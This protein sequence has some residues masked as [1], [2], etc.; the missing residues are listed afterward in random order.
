[1]RRHPITRTCT[2]G[3]LIRSGGGISGF[4]DSLSWQI[5]ISGSVGTD[6]D[7]D[8]GTMN[9]S[10]TI[11]AITAQA[12]CHASTLRTD[13]TE[14]LL[15]TEEAH[16]GQV[17]LRR[18][19]Q[20]RSSTVAATSLREETTERLPPLPG[21]EGRLICIRGMERLLCTR[22]EGIQYRQSGLAEHIAAVQATMAGG[23]ITDPPTGRLLSGAGRSIRLRAGGEHSIMRRPRAAEDLAQQRVAEV[24]SAEE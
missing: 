15:R 9:L 12:G 4:R 10:A 17:R 22:A 13:L 21:T 3:F 1:M 11:S 5:L 16:D 14:G 24:L 18:E 20:R 6:M 8:M 7:T 19:V 23:H 2:V